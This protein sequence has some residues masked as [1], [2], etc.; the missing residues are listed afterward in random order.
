MPLQR[1]DRCLSPIGQPSNICPTLLVN[2]P[3][4]VAY[5]M[6]FL[7]VPMLQL[8]NPSFSSSCLPWLGKQSLKDRVSKLELRNEHNSYFCTL[9]MILV[10]PK[11]LID[12]NSVFLNRDL[13]VP[14][15]C[16]TAIKL[17]RSW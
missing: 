12:Y 5:K 8:W 10:I 11:T 13:I 16:V 9:S 15:L 1:Y 2:L 6:A 17:S 4:G 14:T 3:N 7:L